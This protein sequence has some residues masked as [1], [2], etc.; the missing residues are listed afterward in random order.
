MQE[1]SLEG[2]RLSPQQRHLWLLQQEDYSAAYSTVCVVRVRGPLQVGGWERAVAS[3]IERQEI[4]RTKFRLLPGMTTPLQVIGEAKEWRSEQ[5][6]V[7]GRSE[8]EQEESIKQAYVAAGREEWQ[9]GA[10]PLLR[11]KL[12]RLSVEHHAIVISLPAVCG[13]SVGVSNL[14]RE[15]V[16]AYDAQLTAGSETEDPIQYLI[17]SE[18]QNRLVESAETA[19]GREFWN[20]PELRAATAASKLPESNSFP[21]S[22]RFD[23]QRLRSEVAADTLQQV[24]GAEAAF[25]LACWQVLLWR[26]SG[27]PRLVVGT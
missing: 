9:V 11:M 12:L 15:I 17:A 26:L 1:Q 2:Y 23:P 19:S 5:E 10:G 14:V 18:W 27:L 7:S 3:V 20:D 4:L 21:K 8:A 25:L 13:D 22:C 24:E 6:D 16:H